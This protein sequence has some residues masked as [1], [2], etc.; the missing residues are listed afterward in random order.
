MIFVH[1]TKHA[2]RSTV[3]VSTAILAIL[4]SCPSVSASATWRPIADGF[5]DADIVAVAINPSSPL[6]LYA[7]SSQAVYVST[8]GGQSCRERF[9]VP[10]QA[11]VT[12]L[13]VDPFDSRHVLAAT[14][15]GLYGSLDAGKR[16][17]MVLR[18]P[19]AGEARCHT[20]LFH[21]SRRDLILLGTAG[22]LFLSTDAGQNWRK[23]GSR[24]G[25][26]SIL[27]IAADPQQDQ[28]LYAVTDEGL[29]ASTDGAE[30]WDRIFATS[31]PE[32][33]PADQTDS[34]TDE[35]SEEPEHN[36]RLTVV[37]VDPANPQTL[38]LGGSA[39]VSLSSDAGVTWTP[40]GHSGIDGSLIHHLLLYGPSA[41]LFAASD[42]GAFRYDT[43][44]TR[45]E[46]L[47]AGLPTQVVHVLACTE[48]QLFAATRAGLYQLDLTKQ[49]AS[50]DILLSSQAV[51]GYFM[52]EPTITEVQRVAMMY[53]EVHPDKIRRWR[54]EASLHALLPTLK[55]DYDQT[56]DTYVN[57]VASTTNPAYD[58]IF[59][60]TDPSHSFALSF[61]WDLGD[62]IWNGDQT[63]ID[64]RSRLMVQLRDDILNEV[65]RAYFERRRL[66]T[67]LLTEP[68]PAPK[69]HLEKELRLQ[70][71]T[72][73]IDGLTGGWFSRQLQTRGQTG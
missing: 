6:L 17:T 50:Q 4:Q 54:Q 60:A 26:R 5:N 57:G 3:A 52:H 23:A 38:Y 59:T 28:R 46:P 42:R 35:T 29:F 8:N 13:A 27:S 33:S 12:F 51:F 43:P 34:S 44:Q 72:A 63:S 58:R 55:L 14:D 62:L 69:A 20:I 9:R 21:P 30:T 7:A 37:A 47:Y 66:Q 31:K 11:Q 53:A 61:T 10:A 32:E 41:Q 25:D 71:L 49:Q 15:A 1:S 70:E 45:W 19:G 67:E 40:L 36:Q 65:T 48:T 16:W 18:A 56:H 24:L 68:P 39:G 2:L 73:A 64:T 22:G